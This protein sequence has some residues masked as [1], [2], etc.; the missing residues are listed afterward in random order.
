LVHHNR[1]KGLAAAR[2]TG[3]RMAQGEYLVP[4]DAD[5][6]LMTNFLDHMLKILIENPESSCV[7][8]DFHYFGTIEG[9]LKFSMQDETELLRRQ[10]LPGPGILMHKTLWEHTGGYCEDEIFKYGNEDWDFYLSAQEIGFMPI[11]IPESLY[12]Y[13]QSQGSLSSRLAFFDYMTRELMYKRHHLLFDKHKMRDEFLSEGYIHSA[14]VYLGVGNNIKAFS[15][16]LAAMRF[17]YHRKDA[18]RLALKSLTPRKIRQ[19][20][21]K[22]IGLFQE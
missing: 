12:Y 2:N 17:H 15:L 1:N 18:I 14:R 4:L 21:Q 3:I 13:R 9:D 7:F 20:A 19:T 11:H 5:D 16:S 10:W 22:I 8:P 6:R